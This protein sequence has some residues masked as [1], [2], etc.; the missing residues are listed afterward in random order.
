MKKLLLLLLFVHV[1]LLNVYC[2]TPQYTRNDS[3]KIMKLLRDA[4]HQDNKTNM[5]IYFARQL[6]G[7]PYVAKTLEKNKEENLII[8]LRQLDCTTYVENVLAL[9]LCNRNGR[10]SFPD[11]CRY[12]RLIRYRNGNV[13]YTSRLHYFSEWIADNTSMGYVMEK[14][15]PNPPFTKVQK[16]GIDYMSTH[17]NLYPMLVGNPLRIKQIIDVE[18]KLNGHEYRYIPKLE[19]ANNELFRQTIKDGDIIAITTCTKGLD[20]SHIGIAVWHKDGL[21]MLN[22]SSVRHKVVEET[23]TLYAYMKRHPLQQGIRIIKVND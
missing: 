17:S 18:N 10:T 4:K 12:I 6:C 16:L 22:A 8:N 11:F 2:A 15:F 9:V 3:L 5:M 1:L 20:T 23:M 19:I 21:H 14:Q 7:V 13:S